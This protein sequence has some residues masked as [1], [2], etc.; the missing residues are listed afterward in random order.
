MNFFFSPTSNDIYR[1][2]CFCFPAVNT[3]KIYI[4]NLH[5]VTIFKTHNV[6]QSDSIGFPAV[7]TQIRFEWEKINGSF[8]NNFEAELKTR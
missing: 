2:S 5:P 3:L 8:H 4:N 1:Y 6:A 7:S